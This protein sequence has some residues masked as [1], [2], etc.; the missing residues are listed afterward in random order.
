MVLSVIL[1]IAAAA[2]SGLYHGEYEHP[3]AYETV[4]SVE[5]EYHQVGAVVN[6]VPT[7]TSYQSRTDYHSEPIVKSVL[8]SVDYI[9]PTIHQSPAIAYTS[10]AV[11]APVYDDHHHSHEIVYSAPVYAHNSYDH[12]SYD[13]DSYAH[14][15]VHAA[16][17][18]HLW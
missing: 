2:P 7:A 3:I 12:D 1:T 6:H 5:P 16:P 14:S 4:V 15:S 17:L 10:P 11:Y 13:H 9:Q 8:A 18:E